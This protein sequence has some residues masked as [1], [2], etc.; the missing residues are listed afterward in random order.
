MSEAVP[1]SGYAGTCQPRI[2]QPVGEVEQ[3]VARV[4]ALRRSARSRVGMPVCGL[5]SQSSSNGPSF[6]ISSARY[7]PVS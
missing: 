6:G 4:L 2:A 3:R 5:L 1:V 7:W